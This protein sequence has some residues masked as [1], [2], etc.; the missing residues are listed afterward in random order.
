MKLSKL[1]ILLSLKLLERD[2]N[3][4]KAKR[5][6]YLERSHSLQNRISKSDDSIKEIEILQQKI[7]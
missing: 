1:L 6:K 3:K 5:N 2:A 7:M 4:Q